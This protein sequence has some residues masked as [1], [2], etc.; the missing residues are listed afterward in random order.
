MAFTRYGIDP[1]V[2][3]ANTINHV[4]KSM[5]CFSPLPSLA[6]H[7]QHL[8]TLSPYFDWRGWWEASA[9]GA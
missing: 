1:G 6:V 8:D 2:S 3:E 4:Y 9:V 5:P 7:F